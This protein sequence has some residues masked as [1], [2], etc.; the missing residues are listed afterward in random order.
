[1]GEGDRFEGAWVFLG[2]KPAGQV[3][4]KADLDGAVHVYHRALGGVDWITASTRPGL[5]L[6]LMTVLCTTVCAPFKCDLICDIR[7]TNVSVCVCVCAR[8]R[9]F[10]I[11]QYLRRVPYSSSYLR[12]FSSSSSH[13]GSLIEGGG[14]R[15]PI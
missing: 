15:G 1:V 5:D 8:A 11:H 14:G 2:C 9:A 4:V 7:P 6:I 13:S 12:F 10:R 3:F